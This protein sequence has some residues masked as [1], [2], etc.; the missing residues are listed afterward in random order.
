MSGSEE[1]HPSDR[2]LQGAC[3]S[4]PGRTVFHFGTTLSKRQQA[5]SSALTRSTQRRVVL[6]TGP[7]VTAPR[8]PFGP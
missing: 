1:E 2:N 8:I 7:A 3:G 4:R 6:K 5:S